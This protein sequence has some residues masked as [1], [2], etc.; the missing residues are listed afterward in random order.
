VTRNAPTEA[1]IYRRNDD[2]I[3]V[4]KQELDDGMTVAG[5]PFLRLPS[6]S[7]GELGA[8][9]SRALRENRYGVVMADEEIHDATW[10]P[11][12]DAAGVSS[13]AEFHRGMSAAT[14]SASGDRIEVVA[15][16][17]LGSD[18]GI[19]EF[20][21]PL[22]LRDPTR[23]ELGEAVLQQLAAAAAPP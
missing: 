15:A 5:P 17:N 21:S 3:V 16:E 12:L 2:V 20:G 22:V 19:A 14:V 1:T 7:P 11:V 10:L 6:R 4:G 9:V 18:R 13:S 8:A 23:E